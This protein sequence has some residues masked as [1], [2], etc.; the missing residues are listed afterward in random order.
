MEA[1]RIE[2]GTVKCRRDKGANGAWR[3]VVSLL[4]MSG[5]LAHAQQ[6]QKDAGQADEETE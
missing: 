6:R 1:K 5:E 2:L 4:S 3:R